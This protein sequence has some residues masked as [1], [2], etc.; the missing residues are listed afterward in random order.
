MTV[1]TVTPSHRQ[2]GRNNWLCDHVNVV[3]VASMYLMIAPTPESS[4]QGEP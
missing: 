3:T 1:T 2:A 4:P